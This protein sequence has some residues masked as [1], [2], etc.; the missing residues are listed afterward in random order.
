MS[1]RRKG[2]PMAEKK[3][4]KNA[5]MTGYMKPPVHTRFQPGK[6]GNPRGRPKGARNVDALLLKA[7][8]AKARITENAK[9]RT[10]S[11]LEI[12]FAQLAN[13]AASGNTR[14]TEVLLKRFTPP[15]Q[16]IAESP[17]MEELVRQAKVG[18]IKLTDEEFQLLQKLLEKT[19]LSPR[20]DVEDAD[21]LP[22]GGSVTKS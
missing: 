3:S 12:A 19:G 18:L 21:F 5:E 9:Q 22:E 4:R 8:L 1:C 10:R 17:R 15:R 13:K 16:K 20:L 2:A 14:A 6:S 7:V 11:K